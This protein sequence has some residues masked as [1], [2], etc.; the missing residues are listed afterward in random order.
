M[1]TKFLLA[2][3]ILCLSPL[4]GCLQAGVDVTQVSI[5]HQFVSPDDIPGC[6]EEGACPTTPVTVNLPGFTEK[7]HFSPP[8]GVVASAYIDEIDVGSPSGASFN[9]IQN[10]IVEIASDQLHSDIVDYTP[11]VPP[12]QDLALFPSDVDLLP[13]FEGDSTTF[14]IAITGT[15][16]PQEV[17]L[18]VTIF[19][20]G[21]ISYKKGL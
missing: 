7:V 8:S 12:G 18:D 15:A 10:V 5:H 6:P 17:P 13:Y 11:S 9:F 14:T 2:L 20:N 19:L 3:T 21:E 4:A 16:P 1:T